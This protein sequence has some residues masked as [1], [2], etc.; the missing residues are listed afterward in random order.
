MDYKDLEV[1]KKSIVLVK[2]IYSI[3]N[4]FPKEEKYRLVDQ[5]KRSVVS[6][7]ANFEEGSGRNNTKEFM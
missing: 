5:I 4:N 7:F 1:W 6:I 2:D 3:C